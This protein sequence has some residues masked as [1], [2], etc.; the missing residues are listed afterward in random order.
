MAKR[1]TIEFVKSEFEKEGYKVLSESYT[2]SKQNGINYKCPNGHNSSISWANWRNGSR[3]RTCFFTAIRKDPKLIY[4]SI[5]SEGY[6]ILSPLP[7]TYSNKS[8]FMVSCDKGHVYETSSN[9]WQ[10]GHR[11]K[12]C[13]Y[14]KLSILHRHDINKIKDKILID[15]YILLSGDYIN[16][17]TK[18]GIK[19]DRG[20]IYHVRYN[21][22]QQG[23]RC[24]IC[25]NLKHAISYS[26][27][28]H[29][30]WKGGISFEPYC[31][32]W[33]DKEYK[34]DI[35]NRDGGMCLNPY[36]ASPNKKDLVVHHVN[37]DKKNCKYDNLI[38]ICRSCNIKANK[39]REW[40]TTWYQAI[41]RNRY[42]YVY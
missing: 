35:K 28:G 31:E 36:C 29:P 37:Y 12:V 22:W 39:D 27:A 40:Y 21:D 16:A 10:N 32:I 23:Y 25:A 34:E 42:N 11:C 17:F 8:K 2:N 3:C 5:E 38:T 1:L 41:L 4:D 13:S 24:P 33:K 20:H 19:C 30:N 26:G 14:E 7:E 6:I 15:G 9:K 18:L